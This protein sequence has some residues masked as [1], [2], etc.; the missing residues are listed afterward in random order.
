MHP[1]ARHQYTVHGQGG[2]V[3]PTH[4]V[5]FEALPTHEPHDDFSDL[6]DFMLNNK[7]LDRGGFVRL[8]SG[9][10]LPKIHRKAGGAL[11]DDS[12][13]PTIADMLGV[14]PR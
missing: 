7:D 14:K 2:H 8:E 9:D 1:A 13:N 10:E 4:E 3:A 12:D 11:T 6:L 5:D